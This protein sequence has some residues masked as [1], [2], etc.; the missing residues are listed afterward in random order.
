MIHL[1]RIK[2]LAFSALLL[3]LLFGRSIAQADVAATITCYHS[4]FKGSPI[5]AASRTRPVLWTSDFLSYGNRFEEATDTSNSVG[6]AE[7][8]QD[9]ASGLVYMQAGY[10]NADIRRF[11]EV[12]PDGFVGSNPVSF[13]RYSYAD[14]KY[15]DPDGDYIEPF[16][17]LASLGSALISY[18]NN[19]S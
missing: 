4:H 12:D 8:I 15:L 3:I 2:D 14:N 18:R 1:S 19:V 9:E 5:A 10:Y 7:H 16:I 17:D 11:R 6:F 13:N